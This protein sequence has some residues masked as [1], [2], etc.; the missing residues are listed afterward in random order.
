LDHFGGGIGG[1]ENWK[2]KKL[3]QTKRFFGEASLG[4]NEML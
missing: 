4:V 2:L 3:Q 1:G